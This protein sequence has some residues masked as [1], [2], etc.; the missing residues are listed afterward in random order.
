VATTAI[1]NLIR[2]G[3]SHQIPGVIETGQRLGMQTMDQALTDLYRR[4]LVTLEEVMSRAVN[5]EHMRLLLR[6]S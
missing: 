3:K 2:E 1:R 6:G 5:P 4:R